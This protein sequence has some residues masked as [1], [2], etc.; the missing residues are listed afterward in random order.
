MKDLIARLLGRAPA[1]L[2]TLTDHLYEMERAALK[3]G[4]A[5][6]FIS[7]TAPA[8]FHPES[9]FYDGSTPKDAQKFLQKMWREIA[10]AASND[11]LYWTGM[12]VVEPHRDGVPSWHYVMWV[13]PDRTTDA[14]RL[15]RS[16][17]RELTT[18][19]R[20]IKVE[21]IRRGGV[22]AYVGKYL[23]GLVSSSEMPRVLAWSVVW[24]IRLVTLFGLRA[25]QS[26]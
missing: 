25:G 21:V 6:L 17:C 2:S 13:S 23:Q 19:G 15:F 7:L 3:S 14:I 16:I 12:R 5:G 1:R 22:V 26:A 11:Y 20:C 9:A 8:R 4:K 24:R 18:D 10:R